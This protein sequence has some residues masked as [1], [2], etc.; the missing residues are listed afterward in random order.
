[1]IAPKEMPPVLREG[2]SKNV[3]GLRN[4]TAKDILHLVC[5]DGR[6]GGAL[7]RGDRNLSNRIPP[8]IHDGAEA[9]HIR[10]NFH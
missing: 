1:M 6:P 2:I 9:G 8:E 4:M 7:A 5:H 3:D 10:H